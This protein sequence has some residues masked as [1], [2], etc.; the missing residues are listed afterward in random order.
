MSTPRRLKAAVLRQRPS[1]AN[2]PR[3]QQQQFRLLW[4]APNCSRPCEKGPPG[5]NQKNQKSQ[6]TADSSYQAVAPGR[7]SKLRGTRIS[8]LLGA[9]HCRAP[10]FW[11]HHKQLNDSPQTPS[12]KG[13]A[14]CLGKSWRERPRN[15][16]KWRHVFR[17][18]RTRLRRDKAFEVL[19]D[20]SSYIFVHDIP[21]SR[22]CLVCV[23]RKGYEFSSQTVSEIGEPSP[24]GSFL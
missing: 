18:A 4:T 8:L 24:C 6:T 19:R 9:T 3:D 2:L 10:H 11:C 20:G 1:F 22:R 14:S 16:K 12:S 7:S 15:Q 17:L 13:I 23:P 21:A 5:A